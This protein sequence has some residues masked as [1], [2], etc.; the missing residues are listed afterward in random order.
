MF[1]PAAGQRCGT[2]VNCCDY[3]DYWSAT[4]SDSNGAD[5]VAF[6]NFDLN[7]CTWS[8]RY[9]GCSVRLVQDDSDLPTVTTN[10]ITNITQT[11][12]TG[13]GNVINAGGSTVTARGVCWSTSHNPTVSG[14]HTTNG[15]GAGSF[16][17]NITGLTANTTYY[18]RAYATNNAGT[19][20]GNEVSFTTLNS[21]G[22][23]HEYVD[24]GLPSGLL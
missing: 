6:N 17:S 2:D 20:Y 9:N 7:A 5:E 1:L 8:N 24:L 23:N 11:T 14:N 18:V 22:N 19:A 12:A 15:T 21:G 16:T 10:T 3:A 13:G 4:C